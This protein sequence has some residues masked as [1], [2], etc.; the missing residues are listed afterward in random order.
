MWKAKAFRILPMVVKAYP[1]YRWLFLTLTVRNRHFAGRLTNQIILP[2]RTTKKLQD[3]KS[4]RF[5][6]GDL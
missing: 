6:I 1:K 5:K 4:I 2:A 3:L